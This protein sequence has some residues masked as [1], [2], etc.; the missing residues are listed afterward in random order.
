MSDLI[1]PQA[2]V[3]SGGP[4]SPGGRRA[5]LPF[6]LVLLWIDVLSWS[7]SIPVYP[8][9]FQHFTGGD[10]AQASVLVGIFMTGFAAI[11]LF[12]APVL[13]ALS[14]RYG[15]RPIILFAL[16]GLGVDLIAM[17]LAPNLWWLAVTRVIHAITAASNAAA[18]AYIADITAPEDR[19]KAFGYTGAAFGV[20]FI[21]GPA[22]GGMLAEIDMRLPFLVGAGLALA[23]FAYGY[24]VMPESLPKERRRKFEIKNANPFGALKFI[25]TDKFVMMLAGVSFLFNLAH[26]LYPSIWVLYT[27][28]RFGWS[29]QMVGWMLALSGVFGAIVQGVLV[30]PVVKRIGERAAL[31]IGLCSWIVAFVV[32]GLA[33]ETWHFI[34]A[35][36][37]G[38]LSGFAGPS[39]NALI[40]S[41]IAPDRQGELQ[42][43]LSSLTSI[44]G[45]AG[46]TLFA[47]TF[48][49]VSAA[50]SPVPV[51]GLPFF[52]AAALIVLATMLANYTTG[53]LRRLAP[54]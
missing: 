39:L 32:G 19:A 40:T 28:E 54:A 43:A 44:A 29:S 18:M 46:P 16:F 53:R 34:A 21:V 11:Q 15:R 50:N 37:L 27:T 2:P 49:Y 35:L 22:A 20:G 26:W 10:V 48:A 25:A 13:G 42:G 41:R 8:K 47:G 24:F 52:I 45:L 33:T 23:N 31:I 6:I 5:A 1:A 3:E 4:S 38:A 36:P 12:A 51:L 9:L 30:G 14:D 7:I 17:A